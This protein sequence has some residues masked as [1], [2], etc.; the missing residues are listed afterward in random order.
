MSI[1]SVTQS[2]MTLSL[3]EIIV[4]MKNHQFEL[5]DS[6]AKR[7]KQLKEY[8]MDNEKTNH[9]YIP[10]IV[11]NTMDDPSKSKTLRK[12][13]V[14]DGSQRLEAIRL[15][16]QTIMNKTDSHDDREM[17]EAYKQLKSFKESSLAFQV[18]HGLTEKSRDQLF[19]DFNT[20]GKKVALSKLIAYDS[21]TE[22]NQITNLVLLQ[23]ES[24]KRA[25]VE[26]EKRALIKPP[27]R[28]LLSL[29]QLRLIV[30]VFLIGEL[31]MD[32]PE[33]ITRKKSREDHVDII[34]TW[35]QCLFQLQP[36]ETIGDYEVTMLASHT[37][38]LALAYYAIKGT[39]N[40][41]VN[42]QKKTVVQR[43][44][45]LKAVNWDY[46]NK[47]WREFK[48]RRK[49]KKGY[50]YLEHERANVIKLVDWFESVRG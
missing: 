17:E 28:N 39:K 44:D 50:F 21:R 37:V 36:P 38:Q 30:T 45:K 8:F 26:T 11:V 16:H 41:S 15:L 43:M 20:K 22:I 23:N 4:M 25:G 31:K 13:Q 19:V 6:Y 48:G 18:F 32:V 10:P 14:I 42:E 9:I 5:R 1:E 12:Y 7:V 47:K 2:Y 34:N 33:K 27:N 46:S 40:L 24:L 35:F 49:G 3:E 29:S